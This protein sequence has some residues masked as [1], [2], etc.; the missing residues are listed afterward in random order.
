[1]TCEIRRL[2]HGFPA[3]RD[4][5][6]MRRSNCPDLS[7]LTIQPRTTGQST[8]CLTPRCGL[9]RRPLRLHQA[10]RSSLAT[11]RRGQRPRRPVPVPVGHARRAPW[12]RGRV[13]RPSSTAVTGLSD[14]NPSFARLASI[15]SG[16]SR[17]RSAF[18]CSLTWRPV[19]RSVTVTCKMPFKS[20]A[21]LTVTSAKP[22]ERFGLQRF[23]PEIAKLHVVRRHRVLPLIHLDVNLRLSRIQCRENFAFVPRHGGVAPDQGA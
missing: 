21:K 19:A 13:L 3:G 20:R 18:S 9:R 23:H 8:R 6:Y 2:A 16:L 4:A 15:C 10:A 17:W 7:R 11:A 12:C 5:V 22:S 14:V 1:M